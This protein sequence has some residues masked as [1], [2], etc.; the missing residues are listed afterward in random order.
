MIVCLL[1]CCG[2]VSA[3]DMVKSSDDT[4]ALLSQLKQPDI[5]EWRCKVEDVPNGQLPSIDD[6]TWKS[7]GK[8]EFRWTDSAPVAWLRSHIVIPNK[9]A[10]VDIAGS[11]IVLKCGADDDGIIYINGGEGVPFH[12]DGGSAVL[13]EHAQPGQTFDIAIKNTNATGEGRLL[14]ARLEYSTLTPIVDSAEK[15]LGRYRAA[16][17]TYKLVDIKNREQYNHAIDDSIAA[18]DVNALQSG[19]TDAFLESL[20]TATAKFDATKGLAKDFTTY[21]VGHAHID[22]N[23]LWLWPETIDVCKN[24]FTSVVNLMNEFPEFNYEQSQPATYSVMQEK[25]PELFARIKDAVKRGQWDPIGTT[26]VEGDLNMSSGESIVRSIL[27]G[28]RYIKKQFGVESRICWEPDTFG[29]P[30][31][32]PQILKKSGIDYY[33]FMRCA[34]TA[35][36]F[37]WESP[38]GSRV[39]GYSTTNYSGNIISDGNLGGAVEFANATSSRDFMRTYGV[40]DHGGGPSRD[41][42]RS[43]RDLQ[44]REEYPAVKFST[45]TD[46]FNLAAKTGEKYP[47]WNT[48]MNSIFE[49]CYTTHADIKRWN[50]ECESLLPTAESFAVCAAKGG[51]PYSSSDFERSWR[52]TCFNQFHDILCGSAIHG[53]YDYSRQLYN[54]IIT[55]GKSL[56]NQSLDKLTSQIDTKGTGIPIIVFNPLA[57]S[58]TGPV[59]VTSPFPGQKT[60]VRITDATG[61]SYPGGTLGDTLS[62]TARDVPGMGYKVFWANRTAKP[63]PTGVSYSGSV[64]E[65]Q[66]FRVAVDP[67]LGVI[68]SI[69]DKLNK[70]N[71]TSQPS[72]VLQI[73][74]EEPHGMSAWNIG[75]FVSSQDVTGETEV[76]CTESTAAKVTFTYDHAYGNS[77]FTQELTLYDNVPRID[78]KMTA[79]WKEQSAAKQPTP[80]LKAL[81]NV[82]LNKPKATFEIPFGSIERPCDGREVVSQ[83]WVDLSDS[84]YGVSL[85][86]D[87]KYGFDIK[88]NNMRISLLRASQDPDPTPDQGMHEMTYSLY[89]H[90]GDWR[91][92]GTVR[93][94]YEINQPLIARIAKPQRGALPSSKSYAN[95]SNDNIII[96][97]LK[98][99]ED[100]SNII[101]RFYETH[102]KAGDATIRTSL[103][104]KY[105]METDLMERPIGEKQ[106]IRNGS[107]T[108]KTG[109]YE[110]K[111]Y[112]LL[113]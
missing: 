112:K 71:V 95:V 34:Q 1:A 73:L 113:R 7:Y 48:E 92:A 14:F 31:T 82:D 108:V 13:T 72:D 101:L 69:Y 38:D 58:R 5:A 93:K 42:I 110:I 32:V 46:Y 50:R 87:C 4:V 45:A 40:G 36:L 3:Q 55:Q 107:F 54:E 11:Q 51:Q 29:H 81:F 56:L 100:D 23:W 25:Y 60:S 97:A 9:V 33:Y 66:F 74:M 41:M 80:M 91:T 47:I 104:V 64:L 85:L 59:S 103:P 90:K 22:M 24:T 49:G 89:P 37:W 57:W 84:N 2:V 99:A 19:K 18:V 77:L 43:A 39:L 83:K 65:N 111:T 10:G 94:G 106:P 68:T 52:K 27:Y 78:I 15:Y 70:R 28:K 8:G 75:K 16:R 76:V 62:F 98:K 109:K 53:S 26:W 20:K 67:K 96:T 79:D 61:K 86:N 88:D 12:W 6:S 63:V 17:E 30:W 105:Y 21:I 102:G 44:T 35:P